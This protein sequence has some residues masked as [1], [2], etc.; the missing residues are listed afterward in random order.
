VTT[1]PEA[2][3]LPL[4]LAGDTRLFLIVGDP[5]A[6]VGSP[7][8]FNAAFRRRGARA[9][10]SPAHVTAAGLPAFLAGLRLLRNLGGI[11]ITIPHKIAFMD[12]VDRIEA[13]GR[14]VGAVNAVRCDADG[15]WVADNFDG[16]GCMRG[17]AEAGGTVAGRSV[18]LIGAGGA[19]SAIAHAVADRGPGRLRVHDT[20]ASRLDRLLSGLGAA[21]PLL[22]S[23][24]GPPDPEG[25]DVVINATP[26]GM[27]AGDPLPVAPERIRPDATVIDVILKPPVSPLLAAAEARGCTVQPGLRMLAGQVEAIADFFGVEGEGEAAP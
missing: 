27:R 23:E 21:H 22:A 17:L 15:T 7:R 9:V 6:Q 2:E 4:P 19:G 18:L 10:L 5:I 25:F 11:V 24:G 20:D 3:G 16:E 1:A 26:L 12:H 8:L 13:N 14:R